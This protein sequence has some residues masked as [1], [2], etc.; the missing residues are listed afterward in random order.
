M[1][2]KTFIIAE[3]SGNHNGDIK[4]AKEII[5]IAKEVGADAVKLQTYTADSLTL[6]CDGDDFVEKGLLWKGMRSYDLYMQAHTP[7]EW[8]EEL[9]DYARSLDLVCFSTPFDYAAVDLLESLGNP[10]Y[11]IASFE[12][13]DVNL[14]RYAASKSK[15]MIIST[16]VSTMDDLQMAVDVCHEVGNNDITFLK[17]TSA[18]PA[19]LDKA[20]LRT[21]PFLADKFGVKVGVSDHSLSDTIPTT[22]VALGACAVEKHLMID[23]KLGGPDSGFSLEPAEFERMVKAIRDVESALG[24]VYCPTDPTEIVGRHSCR[25]LYVAENVKKGEIFTE[26]NVRSVRPGY[27]LH[28]KYLPDILG[29]VAARDL[30][31]GE[32][33]SMDMIKL[34]I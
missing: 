27:G 26:K 13:T 16:G 30:K 1:N 6:N 22:A 34:E 24:T 18:Y 4:R 17:C 20:N 33:F 15:P 10:I 11:K 29:K 3:M 25:S 8:H 19:P 2:K 32:R 12:I 7:W 5:K 9:F 23:R 28:P 14:I 21:I 31:M